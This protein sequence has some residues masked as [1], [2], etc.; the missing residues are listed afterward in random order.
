MPI[1]VPIDA[2]SDSSLEPLSISIGA[3]M[4][5]SFLSVTTGDISE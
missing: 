1:K 3:D 4:S 5:Y 2:D